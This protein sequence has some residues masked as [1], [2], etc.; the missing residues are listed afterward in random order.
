[1]TQLIIVLDSSTSTGSETD[2]GPSLCFWAAYVYEPLTDTHPTNAKLSEK[3]RYESAVLMKSSIMPPNRSGAIYNDHDTAI[4]MFYDGIIRAMNSCFYLLRKHKINEVI[5]LGDCN[6]VVDQI[7]GVV[8]P[9]APAI[10]ALCN[11]VK[12]HIGKYQKSGTA[13]TLKHISEDNYPLYR[14]IDAL[15]KQVR[16]M[17]HD[18]LSKR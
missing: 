13:V 9:K 2:L 14:D 16:G 5:I 10:V 6:P 18:K 4:K 3:T 17:I 11:Q 1:M 7:N 15:A 8:S 12:W